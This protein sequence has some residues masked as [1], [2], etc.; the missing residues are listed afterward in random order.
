M[1]RGEEVSNNDKTTVNKFSVRKISRGSPPFTIPSAL[2]YVLQ[3]G[4]Y[5]GIFLIK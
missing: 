3:D 2:S 5:L 1:K 4:I